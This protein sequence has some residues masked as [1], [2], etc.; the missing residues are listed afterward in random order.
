M[1]REREWHRAL[2]CALGWGQGSIHQRQGRGGSGGGMVDFVPVSNRAQR[3]PF[4][5]ALVPT[6]PV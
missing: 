5:P 6:L 3:W 2:E 4:P 1:E